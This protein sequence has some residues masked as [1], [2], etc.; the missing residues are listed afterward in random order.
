MLALMR[1]EANGRHGWVV[2]CYFFLGAL[3]GLFVTTVS[4][5]V[6][7]GSMVAGEGE[8]VAGALMAALVGLVV[9]YIH[10]THGLKR[11]PGQSAGAAPAVS[12]ARSSS[13]SSAATSVAAVDTPPSWPRAVYFHV[14]AL[15]GLIA[16]V[17]G[18]VGMSGAIASLLFGGPEV[19]E[20]FSE[21]GGYPGLPSPGQDLVKNLLI[22][23]VGLLIMWWHLNEARKPRPL[24][25]AGSD[26]SGGT[27]QPEA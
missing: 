24:T 13:S 20:G 27:T 16:A 8:G 18:A 12:D 22:A 1:G 17:S 25:R 5:V 21:F 10:L 11:S 6:A 4:A 26:P 2:L 7:V 23:A 19:P 14:G 3:L 15:V 9:L